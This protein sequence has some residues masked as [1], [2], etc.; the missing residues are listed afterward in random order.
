MIQVALL[1]KHAR[2]RKSHDIALA[3]RPVLREQ[4][5]HLDANI[6]IV[7]VPPG[8]PLAGSIVAEIY[9]PDYNGQMAVAR[10][11]RAA[12]ESTDDV[13]DVDD[14]MEAPQQKWIVVV[15]RARA[16]AQGVAEAAITSTLAAALQGSDVT[17]LHGDHNQ[18]PVPVRLEFSAGD[19]ASLDT[20]RN[21]QVRTAGGALIPIADVASFVP[22]SRE[23]PIYHKDLLPVV[24]VTG[25]MVGALDSP[26]Y[27][28]AAIASKLANTAIEGG[29]PI[30]MFWTRPPSLP[31][32]WSLKWDGEWQL[33][34]ETFRDLGLAYAVGLTIIYL[35][36]VVQFRSYFVPLIIMAPI[37]LT[38]IGVAFGHAL[39]GQ[40]FSAT[41][42]MGLIALAGILVRNS[43]LLVDFI[44]K[45]V[46]QGQGLQEA[47]LRSGSVRAKPII[48]TALAAIAGALFILD[49]P[50][51]SG[52]AVSIIFGTSVSTL[53]TL[54]VIPVLYYAYSYRGHS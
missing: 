7:E 44:Q 33:T 34:Y 42:L 14:T 39:I 3:L 21:L 49:D 18:Y 25:E 53:L 36:I 27:G 48:L 16:S 4:A 2:K 19:K 32:N 43:I 6:K 22:A 38:V 35:L 11:V 37:P 47:V 12:F 15:D 29:R 51:Y 28:M 54:F 46:N 9:G 52:L 24:L 23:S 8:P 13:V 40:Q 45:A 1:D 17:Y 31:I 20:L 41:S 30:D 10:E 5:R 26:L 50:S